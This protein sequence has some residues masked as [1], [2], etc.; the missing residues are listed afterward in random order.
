METS[1]VG[2]NSNTAFLYAS[3]EPVSSCIR[4]VCQGWRAERN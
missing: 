1:C 4:A 2:D 3:S